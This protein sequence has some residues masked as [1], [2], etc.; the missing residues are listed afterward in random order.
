MQTFAAKLAPPDK[1]APDSRERSV[2][3]VAVTGFVTAR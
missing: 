1:H 3:D 2:N